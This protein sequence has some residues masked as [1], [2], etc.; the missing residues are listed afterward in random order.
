MFKHILLPTDGSALSRK[1][2]VN[3][4]QLARDI[5]AKITGFY[6][7]PVYQPA[8]YEDFVPSRF[9]SPTRQRQA[10]AKLAA[11]HLGAIAR[12]RGQALRGRLNPLRLFRGQ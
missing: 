3:G 11:K 12:Q 10:I 4:V 7:A 2:I 6:A 5:G 1:A 8:V 9:M